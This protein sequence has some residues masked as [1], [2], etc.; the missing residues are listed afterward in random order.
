MIGL[1]SLFLLSRAL[2]VVPV[3]L[4]GGKIVMAEVARSDPERAEGLW[5]REQLGWDQGMLFVFARPGPNPFWMPPDMRLRLDLI[6]LDPSGTVLH[7]EHDLGP[8][9]SD[10]C[11]RYSVPVQPPQQDRTQYVLEVNAGYAR[12]AGLKP[13]DRLLW[14]ADQPLK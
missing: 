3:T 2:P 13:G 11:P 9:R 6:F 8:C 14:P 7:I 4:P 10:P 5:H 1:F 12:Q